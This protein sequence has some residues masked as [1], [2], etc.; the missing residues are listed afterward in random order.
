MMVSREID[1]KICWQQKVSSVSQVKQ[2]E[3]YFFDYLSFRTQACRLSW[4]MVSHT[5]LQKKKRETKMKTLIAALLTVASFNA[6]AV[7]TTICTGEAGVNCYVVD[8][9]VRPPSA[10]QAPEMCMGGEGSSGIVCEV[11]ADTA[12]RTE[13]LGKFIEKHFGYGSPDSSV[14]DYRV[15]Y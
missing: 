8:L 4:E 13:K 11:S 15:R 12:A 9:K 10:P 5:G 1:F 3:T 6:M 7:K 14:E 2:K